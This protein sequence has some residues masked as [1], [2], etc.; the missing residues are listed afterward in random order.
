MFYFKVLHSGSPNIE[1][2]VQELPEIHFGQNEEDDHQKS[3][4]KHA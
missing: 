1:Q 4:T 3:Q 2:I